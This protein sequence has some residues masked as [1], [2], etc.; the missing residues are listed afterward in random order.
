M[1]QQQDISLTVP[2]A[3]NTSPSLI[4]SLTTTDKS[5]DPT[6]TDY[7]NDNIQRATPAQ[8]KNNPHTKDLDQS[9]YMYGMEKVTRSL[10]DRTCTADTEHSTEI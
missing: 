1:L 9:Q 8:T 4:E 10:P 5:T 7:I 6:N 3:T 2:T